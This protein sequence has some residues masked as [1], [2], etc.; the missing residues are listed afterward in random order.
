MFLGTTIKDGEG[1]MVVEVVM[2]VRFD[3]S[4]TGY[5]QGQRD[6]QVDI[7]TQARCV[8]SSLDDRL[9]NQFRMHFSF[10]VE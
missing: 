10:V 8:F 9:N 5:G 7:R 6:G 3:D 4:A 1:E 2:A